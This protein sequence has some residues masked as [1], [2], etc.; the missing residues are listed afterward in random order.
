[1]SESTTIR[2]PNNVDTASLSEQER[3]FV[4]I[5][6]QMEDSFKEMDT[7]RESRYGKA[8]VAT[9]VGSFR[10]YP[11]VQQVDSDADECADFDPR[12]T[13]WYVSSI[14]GPKNVILIFDTSTSMAGYNR[15]PLSQAASKSVIDT[16]G[17]SDWIG[18]IRFDSDAYFV[19]NSLTRATESAKTTIKNT[20]DTLS[21]LGGTNYEAAFRK[22]F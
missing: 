10:S 11:S 2:F 4:C 1:M 9:Q 22:T 16:L 5:S 12:Y 15:I 8:Y 18:M 13:P 20:I 6:A 21:P 17:N 19:T 14:S 3:E 7:G